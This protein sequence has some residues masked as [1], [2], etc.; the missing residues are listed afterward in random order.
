[1]QILQSVFEIAY[2]NLGNVYLDLGKNKLALDCFEKVLEI[3]SDNEE[4][5]REIIELKGK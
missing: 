1:V 5:L 2:M 3:S 4:A